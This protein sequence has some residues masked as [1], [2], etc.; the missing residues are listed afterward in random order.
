MAAKRGLDYMTAA[1][2]VEFVESFLRRNCC[3]TA[4]CNRPVSARSMGNSVCCVRC[5]DTQGARHTPECDASDAACARL[6]A[7][8]QAVGTPH[9]S[10]RRCLLLRMCVG[11]TSHDHCDASGGRHPRVT[12]DADSDVEIVGV[13]GSDINELMAHVCFTIGCRRQPRMSVRFTDTHGTANA[14]ICCEPCLD[15]DG[16]SAECD[17]LACGVC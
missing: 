8:Q 10:G 9:T 15:G 5:D 7:A 2:F 16:H 17:F 3:E 6:L 13:T 4:G 1:E 14:N 11:I 12:D